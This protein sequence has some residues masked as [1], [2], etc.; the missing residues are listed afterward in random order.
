MWTKA[1]TYPVP[2]FYYCYKK[3]FNLE[4]GKL[5][6]IALLKETAGVSAVFDDGTIGMSAI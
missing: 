2:I 5:P 6:A 3:I 1:A 4:L